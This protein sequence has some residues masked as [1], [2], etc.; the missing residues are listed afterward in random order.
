[1]FRFGKK[2]VIWKWIISYVCV[3]LTSMI[4]NLVTYDRSKTMISER[5]QKISE[6]VLKQS[7]ER[8]YDS[9]L[10][11][12]NLR[13]Q[14]LLNA[15]FSSLNHSKLKLY[16]SATYKQ[17]LLYEDL[18]SYQ[19]ISNCY[20]YLLLYFEEDDKVIASNSVNRSSEYWNIYQKELGLTKEQWKELLSGTYK[21]FYAQTVYLRETE[22]TI[23]ARTIQLKQ[24]D[25]QKVNMFVIYTKEDLEKLLGGYQYKESTS[26]LLLDQSGRAAVKLD[27]VSL[28]Q[29]KE[30]E[31]LVLDA[32]AKG[33]EEVTLEN[34]EK[35]HL[36]HFTNETVGS[37]CLL[38]PEGVYLETVKQFQMIFTI[39]FL[40]TIVFSLILIWVFIQNNYKPVQALL[41]TLGTEG[42]DSFKNQNEFMLMKEGV[43][44]VKNEYKHVNGALKKQNKLLQ[45]VYLARLLSGGTIDLC[46]DELKEMY[47]IHFRFKDCAVIL[48]YIE[49]IVSEHIVSSH[50]AYV[51]SS[52]E[53][54][55]SA[56]ITNEHN[57]NGTN[58][59][60]SIVHDRILN[61]HF[62]DSKIH[63]ELQDLE[64]AQ[65][66]LTNVYTELFH[67]VNCDVYQTKMEDILVL[68]VN[69]PMLEKKE[70]V[71]DVTIRKGNA[72][73][74][75]YYNMDYTTVVSNFHNDWKQMATAYQ[76]ALQALEAKKLY[77]LDNLV[78]YND[79]AGLTGSS[80]NYSYET[81]LELM[82]SIQ[83]SNFENAKAIFE[84]VMEDNI[85][86]KKIISHD[87]MR[88][89]MFDLLGTVLKSF[90]REEVSQTFVKQLK[91]AKRLSDC[92]DLQEMEQVFEEILLRSCE[93]FRVDT[94][95]G[96]SQKLCLQIREYIHKNYWDSNLC[97]TSIANQFS[98]SPVVMSKMFR[99]TMENKIP[100][101]VSEIRLQAA[102]KLMLR[103]SESLGDIAEKAGFG[104][105]KTFTRVFKQ[106][107]G[108]TP[109]Q[110][111]EMHLHIK[112]Q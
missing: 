79:I 20:S 30:D 101:L 51:H 112:S 32:I 95:S 46:E 36:N 41:K 33:K 54:I 89:L 21:S 86:I 63:N 47:D 42:E 52:K 90:D 23:Y 82:R 4:C 17:Y 24:S 19:N 29:S 12:E 72:F 108:C 70:E 75:Y 60:E 27:Y 3:I 84:K 45:K 57:L 100:N 93:F 55:M 16:S 9:I 43:N 69:L 40:I 15:S 85:H 6:V 104:S 111:R 5:Q 31:Q 53:N 38:T 28:L 68:V 66:I 80:Y 56:H 83:M 11:I 74:A 67:E 49:D 81:E 65:F 7:S 64:R 77:G 106:M 25:K 61:E 91:P 94:I 73:I 34:Y 62:E 99:E 109:G 13:E 1:M 107:E 78:H 87:I 48:F 37:L 59:N 103:S 105:T 97:V 18:N 110:W 102:K 14:L 76:E 10:Q 50:S 98:L 35:V 39:T 96:E 58:L 92:W 26:L 88:C 71:L 2:S 44:R 8:I 22:A